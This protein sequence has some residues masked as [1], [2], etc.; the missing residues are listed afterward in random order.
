MRY[1]K[2][3]ITKDKVEKELLK[4]C[5]AEYPPHD[6]YIAYNNMLSAYKNSVLK[7]DSNAISF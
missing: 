6:V 5:E 2:Y 3:L 1:I 7:G 4:F